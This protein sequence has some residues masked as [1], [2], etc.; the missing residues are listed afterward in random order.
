MLVE[1][2]KHERLENPRIEAGF[3]EGFGFSRDKKSRCPNGKFLAA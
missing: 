3:G 2:A 1:V